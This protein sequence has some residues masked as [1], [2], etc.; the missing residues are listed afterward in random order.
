[1]STKR[2]EIEPLLSRDGEPLQVLVVVDSLR[3]GGAESILATL[4]RAAPFGNFGIRVISLGA[5]N[6]TTAAMR[7]VVERAGVT[8]RFLSL[9][10]LAHPRAL[11]SLVSAIRASGASIVHAHLEY[12]TTLVPPAAALT[13]RPSVCTLHQMAVPLPRRDA[14]KERIAV[15][16]GSRS[17]AM[18]FVSQASMESYARR[19]GARPTWRVVPNGVDLTVFTT[20]SAEPPADLRLS[21][22]R[23]VVSIVGALRARKGHADAIAAWPGVMARHPHATL[24]IV[25]SGP[26]EERLRVQ[27]HTLGVDNRVVFAGMRTDVAEIIRA[28]T[29]VALPS[30]SE[31]L[32]TALI[33]AAAC[34]RAAV[35]TDI[36]GV[37][38][39]VVHGQTGLTVPVGDIS[40][41]QGAIV[42][43]IEDDGLRTSMG[44][45]ARERAEA[46]FSMEVW[47]RRLGALY[48]ALVSGD[49]PPPETSV[50]G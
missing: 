50:H 8:T 38:E 9:P 19:Y 1:M 11:P 29:L 22:A 34:G 47:A 25:G 41:L 4:A 46:H 10:R 27:A 7:D 32:P 23:P 12:A 44:I 28:S 36:P 13:R 21:G 33:E 35:A 31:A 48:E 14:V 5:P 43:L 2:D 3:L 15:E 17:D 16:I 18:L 20:S 39:V 26:E 6:G 45:R 30:W 42:R 37:R 24:L 40:A 49:R